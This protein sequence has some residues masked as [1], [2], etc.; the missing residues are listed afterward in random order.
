MKRSHWLLG[1]AALLFTAVAPAESEL[2]SLTNISSELVK[3]RQQ[4]EELHG[5]INQEKEL[6]G[7]QFRSLSNQKSDL[8]I[9][10]NRS[11]LN[12]KEL[13]RELDTITKENSKQHASSAELVPVLKKAITN[14]RAGVENGLPF[15]KADRLQALDDIE[16]RLDTNIVSP[17]KASNQLWAFVEDELMLGKTNGIYKDM[18]NIDGELKLVKVLRI[19]KIAMFYRTNEMEYGVVKRQQDKWQY[20]KLADAKSV[21]QLV[22]L[23]DSFSKN[24]RNGVFTLPNFLPKN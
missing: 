7:D 21:E 1:I 19:G 15:K 2:K 24:I 10:I 23:F 20:E 13:E 11:A 9:R 8:D 18:L 6:F 12:L 4:I 3:I 14:I 16:Q 22:Y 5:Q 17:N